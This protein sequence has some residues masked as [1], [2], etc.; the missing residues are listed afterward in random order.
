MR[1][2][3]KIVAE[4]A[5]ER[6]KSEQFIADDEFPGLK[7]RIRRGAKGIRKTWI[8][9]WEVGGRQRSITFDVVGTTLAAVRKRANELQAKVR[10][11][12][13]PSRG[14]DDARLQ[15]EQVFGAVLRTYLPMKRQ[16]TRVRTYIETERHLL[17][18]LKSFHHIPIAALT[19][20]TIAARLGAIAVNSGVPTASNVRRSLHALLAWAMRQGLITHN[21]A[22]AVE[23]QPVKSRDH[24]IDADGIKAIWEATNTP[25][26][27]SAIVRLLLLTGMRANEVGC[28][29]WQEV[30]AD[31]IEL[32]GERTKNGHPHTVPITPQVEAILAPRQRD[33]DR[34][35]VF[36]RDT[37]GFKGWSSSKRILGKRIAAAGVKMA[38]WRLHDLRRTCATGMH[39]LGVSSDVIETCLNH[40][41][42]FRRGIAG[43]YVRSRLEGPV[44]HAL[45]AW[46]GHV[47]RIAGGEVRGDRIV[48]FKPRRA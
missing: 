11:G 32:P 14:R 26:D 5:L 39:E 6:G 9:K 12:Q 22:A 27:F 46:E 28:L 31:R 30:R 35:F 15:A 45:E 38:P 17:T 16:T 36:G 1:L 40:L 13:D 23:R 44:L 8:F 20:Q 29:H 19:T 18:Y 37:G 3:D 25:D 21:P 47:L 41:S 10:L 7:L 48:P 2:T 42:G 24:V 33:S 34:K 43:V 4:H